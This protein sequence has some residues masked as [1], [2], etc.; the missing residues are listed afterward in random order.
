MPTGYTADIKD[1]ID[2]KTF[3]MNC[4]R[5]FGACVTL[6]DE[7]GGGEAIPEQFE[8]SD[9][10]LKAAEKARQQLAELEAMTPEQR[11][12]AALRSWEDAESR[13][14]ERLD[15]FRKLRVSYESMLAQV[16]AWTPPTPEHACFH[17]FMRSQIEES[18]KFDCIESSYENPAPRMTGEEWA[19]TMRQKYARDETYHEAQHVAE[20]E[21]AKSRTAWV[22]ALRGSLP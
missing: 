14:Q 10:H 22:Q 6:R 17:D 1:G 3:A 9:Y 15:E 8:P 20:V 12:Q 16:N 13:R 5:A 11:E 18:I 21:R 4:A 7:P 2:F 19:E